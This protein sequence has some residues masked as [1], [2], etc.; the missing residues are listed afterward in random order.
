MA[1]VKQTQR[2]RSDATHPDRGRKTR[3][4]PKKTLPGLYARLQKTQAG[5][6]ESK[7]ISEKIVDAIG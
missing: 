3:K 7:R 4:S 2:K 6:E 5:S 1:T